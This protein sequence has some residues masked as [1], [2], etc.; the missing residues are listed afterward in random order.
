MNDTCNTQCGIIATLKKWAPSV[1]PLR[2]GTDIFF[3]F[4]Y[5]GGRVIVVGC[6]LR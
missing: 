6:P 2:L 3:R 5:A 4:S 1:P